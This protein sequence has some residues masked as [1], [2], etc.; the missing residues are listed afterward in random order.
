MV[1]VKFGLGT[2]VFSKET[3]RHGVK[4]GM[5]ECLMSVKV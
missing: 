4:E 2:H 1:F 3:G 5:K